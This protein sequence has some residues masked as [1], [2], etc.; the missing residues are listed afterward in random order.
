[1][2]QGI[3]RQLNKRRSQ[4]GIGIGIWAAVLL[5]LFRIPLTNMIGDMANGYLAA[6]WE[7]YLLFCLLFAIGYEKNIKTQ[8]AARMSKEQYHN[9]RQVLYTGLQLGMLSALFGA[10]IMYVTGRFWME[11]L[12]HMKVA[13]IPFRYLSALLVFSCLTGCFRGYFEG[14]GTKVPTDISKL[15]EALAT[16]AGAFLLAWLLK[17]YGLRVGNFLR[18]EQ[19]QHGFA[20][21]GVALGYLCGSVFGLLFLI[22]LDKM[23]QVSY[24]RQMK[25]EAGTRA[26]EGKRSIV[27]QLG[28]GAVAAMAG[29]LSLQL[30]HLWN[31]AIYAQLRIEGEQALEAVRALGVYYGKYLVVIAIPIAV[32]TAMSKPREEKIL[33]YFKRNEIRSGRVCLQEEMERLIYTGLPVSVGIAVLAGVLMK[34]LFTGNSDA[35]VLM[36]RYGGLV[37][38][39]AS[40][41]IFLNRILWVMGGVKGILV[42]QIP[43]LILQTLVLLFLL[44]NTTFGALSLVIADLCLWLFIAVGESILCIQAY[45]LNF[46]YFKLLVIPLAGSLSMGLVSFLLGTF[47]QGVLNLWLVLLLAIAAGSVVYVLV[48]RAMKNLE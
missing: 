20:A 13:A 6:A 2:K 22:L 18:E 28:R 11:G 10:V 33:Q 17:D 25:R 29:T 36:L 9:A 1:M 42:M 15:V 37:V 27:K 7:S 41:G 32:L 8:V 40:L 30:Y 19:Y 16:V 21:G 43:A 14:C 12:F 3:K 47:L 39:A 34:A 31:I 4:K 44:K 48:I 35:G 23:Y 45:K 24:K 46:S 38:L 5:L 26:A